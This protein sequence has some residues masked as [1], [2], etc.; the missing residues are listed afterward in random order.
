M[1]TQYVIHS[2]LAND[3]QGYFCSQQT[4]H[5]PTL[6]WWRVWLFVCEC[7][8]IIMKQK[9]AKNWWAPDMQLSHWLRKLWGPLLSH[10]CAYLVFGQTFSN[11]WQ[12]CICTSAAHGTQQNIFDRISTLVSSI[13]VQSVGVDTQPH[14]CAPCLTFVKW[15]YWAV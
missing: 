5:H 3:A 15:F 6:H 2:Q 14:N 10:A 11:V 8:M 7:A 9:A 13:C 12:I 1:H 4:L